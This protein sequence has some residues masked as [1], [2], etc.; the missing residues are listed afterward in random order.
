MFQTISVR[1]FTLVFLCC[2]WLIATNA[3]KWA[4]DGNSFYAKEAGE[5]VKITLPQLKPA[6]IVG[7]A[8]LMV[9]GKALTV[10]NY[11]FSADEKKML[12]FTNSKKVWRYK[13][14]GD[15]Y[16]LDLT[17]KK[18]Q[19]LGKDL[20][21]ATLMFAKFSPDGSK[22]AYVSQ[23]NVYVEDLATSKITKLTSDNGTPKLINGTFDWAYEE[24]FSI[25]DGFRWSPDGQS[26]A[27]WQ[28]DANQIR[29]FYLVNNT[30]SIY[31]RVIPIEYPKAGEAPS[32][33]KISVVSVATG[34][35]TWMNVPGDPTQHYIP[36][37]EWTPDGREI[38]IQQ[39][40]RKQNVSN[41]ILCNPNSGETN[42][43]FTEKDEAW[44]AHI[45]EWSSDVTGW[46]WVNNG[47]AFVWTSEQDGWR[48]LYLINRGGK[49]T[50][51]TKG[52]YD[53]IE[54]YCIDEKGS[55]IYFAA[56]PENATQQYLYSVPLTGN[57]NAKLI[58]PAAQKG[59]HDYT[60]APS[61][62][63]AKHSFSN[64]YTEPLEEW[65]SL[66]D[67]K[68]LAASEPIASKIKETPKNSNVSFFKV[69]TEEGVEMDGWMIKPLDFDANKKYPVVFYVYSEPAGANVK[70]SYY[71]PNGFIY[72]GDMAADGYIHIAIDNRGTP[73][74]KGRA[75]RKAIYKNIG[76][77]N[78]RD[79]ALGAKEILKWN[80]ID[81]SR[82]AVWGWSGGG[83][84]TLNL[85]FQYPEIYKTGIAIAPVTASYFYDN[86]Y[87]ERFMGL[88]AENKADYEKGAALTHAKNLRG[89]L[90]L[91]HGTGDDNVHFQNTEMLVNELIKQGKQ[92][93]YM[94]YPNRTHSISEGE[95][96]F[97]HLS[98]LVTNYLKMNCAPGGRK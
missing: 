80:Y 85:M 19:P 56:S 44:V 51:L 18:M 71:G 72:N 60:I 79:Q 74:P 8:D 47:N 9:A 83:S 25:R 86:I 96:T 33:A 48:H 2:C 21:A 98:T 38:I 36:R 16:V 42:T 54:T 41:L 93:T 45:N 34:K 87:T 40:N 78:I 27:Y 6:V 77:L 32:P 67:H 97:Q 53:V 64:Y 70:D 14:R 50:L 28:I 49:A 46:D 15:Y 90:L 82:V 24:E 66:P 92:F 31:S 35:T 5:L 39:L 43:I 94:A 89:N 95:G 22:V 4:K 23:R 69:K 58:T 7:K 10:D 12:L 17:S 59:T 37:M 91:I 62:K 68:T 52:N 84:T 75:W 29:D 76:Q 73:A 26:I 65:V 30:D 55:V 11:S 61:G 20:P 3:Q 88:P 13:T 81:T 63:Y 1:R 57:G